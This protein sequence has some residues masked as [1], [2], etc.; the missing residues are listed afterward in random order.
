MKNSIVQ[1]IAQDNTWLEEQVNEYLGQKIA[2]II[3][4]S[5]YN[6]DLITQNWF[7]DWCA[8]VRFY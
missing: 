1:R 5:N 8:F 4:V 6:L 7:N 3:P 2:T